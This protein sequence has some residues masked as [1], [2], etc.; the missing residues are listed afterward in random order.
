MIT[1][2]K[3]TVKEFSDYSQKTIQAYAKEKQQTEHIP[4]SEAI[5]NAEAEYQH[6]L[7]LGLATKENYLYTI[8]D[9]DKVKGRIW[10]ATYRGNPEIAFIYDILIYPTFQ[11]QGLGTKAIILAEKEMKKHG[12]KFLQLHVFGNNPRAIHVYEKLG[13]KATDI[14]MQK[15]I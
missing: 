15:R 13:L 1:L 11:N 8:Q 3:M 9:D 12:Y 10:L 14:I 2:Q 4:L 7:P 5:K 6:L